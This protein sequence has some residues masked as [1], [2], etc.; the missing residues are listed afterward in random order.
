MGMTTPPHDRSRETIATACAG[1]EQAIARLVRE[2]WP[3]VWRAALAVSGSPE[4]A[5][6]ATQDALDRAFGDLGR[7]ENVA[8][9]ARWLRSTAIN[10]AIDLRRSDGAR[11]QRE[12]VL[13]TDRG[14]PAE[15]H[16]GLTWESQ[17]P[18]LLEACRR[19]T[20]EMRHVLLL[21]FWADMEL[22][23]IAAALE[24]PVGTVK[25]RLA[26]ALSRLREDLL[27]ET[28]DADGLG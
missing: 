8:H 28:E 13:A 9:L 17:D 3:G 10:R 14:R 15:H 22:G 6:D 26:R 7:F 25:S 2:V 23:D 21:H 18:E 27:E 19:L 11:A 12:R 16:D 4:A 1:D 20:P 5:E 24:V